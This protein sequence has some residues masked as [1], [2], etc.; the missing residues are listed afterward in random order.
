MGRQTVSGRTRR[1]QIGWGRGVRSESV[2]VRRSGSRPLAARFA[3]D[4][5]IERVSGATGRRRGGA[6]APERRRLARQ[7]EKTKKMSWHPARGRRAG[8]AVIGAPRAAR[9]VRSREKRARRRSGVTR[10]ACGPRSGVRGVRARALA[11]FETLSRAIAAASLLEARTCV[12]SRHPPRAVVRGGRA[13]RRGRHRAHGH[14]S[15]AF[16]LR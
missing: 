7:I 13:R 9:D 14:R 4:R 10:G 11:P 3:R 12:L 8:L 15:H 1:Q 16:G 2:R 5:S 6:R